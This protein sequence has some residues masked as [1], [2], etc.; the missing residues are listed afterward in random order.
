MVL[1]SSVVIAMVNLITHLDDSPP[2]KNLPMLQLSH[3]DI[4]K[5]IRNIKLAPKE[6]L[7]KLKL[8]VDILVHRLIICILLGQLI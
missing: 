6:K 8:Y 7:F 1:H 3:V 4:T 2:G 5:Y